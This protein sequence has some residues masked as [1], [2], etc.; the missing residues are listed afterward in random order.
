VERNLLGKRGRSDVA[1]ERSRVEPER[2]RKGGG[3][4]RI[5]GS[6]QARKEKPASV[7]SEGSASREGA[8]RC[9]C[10]RGQ[11]DFPPSPHPGAMNRPARGWPLP[12]RLS[13]S[14]VPQRF[15][16]R[17]GSG[18]LPRVSLVPSR[19]DELG[20]RYLVRLCPQPGGPAAGGQRAGGSA[21]PGWRKAPRPPLAAA[22]A[23]PL[24]AERLYEPPHHRREQLPRRA[25]A[26]VERG[27]YAER[28]PLDPLDDFPDLDAV[29]RD[30][31][32]TW[33]IRLQHLGGFVCRL[34][35]LECEH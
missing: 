16:P 14:R 22:P 10:G 27:W 31:V 15:R 6:G 13:M 35:R 18:V 33:R 12:R 26:V 5:S 8:W 11:S 4:D 28:A 21:S 9:G 20:L 29:D 24:G 19:R 30:G 32:A 17:R 2:L 3:V 25:L 23:I 1:S 34:F 7:G